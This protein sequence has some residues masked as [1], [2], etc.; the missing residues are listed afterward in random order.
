MLTEARLVELPKAGF[1]MVNAIKFGPLLFLVK[2]AFF[3]ECTPESKI[4]PFL[5]LIGSAVGPGVFS[6]IGLKFKS[7]GL[8]F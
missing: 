2:V 1:Y 4:P 8:M 5:V 6:R 7:V 3:S